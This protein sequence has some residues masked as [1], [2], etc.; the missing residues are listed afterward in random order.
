MNFNRFQKTNFSNYSSQYSNINKNRSTIKPSTNRMSGNVLAD[1][2]R[3]QFPACTSEALS[4]L[5]SYISGGGHSL[6]G[7]AGQSA[8]LFV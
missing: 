8:P 6:Q 1:L 5:T 3:L 7:Y 2:Y 4:F